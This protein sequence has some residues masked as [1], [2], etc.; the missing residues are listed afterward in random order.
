MIQRGSF[1]T[2]S[3]MWQ[4]LF[5]KFRFSAKTDIKRL[6]V[7]F[8]NSK[9]KFKFLKLAPHSKSILKQDLFVFNELFDTQTSNSYKK[10]FVEIGCGDGK[11]TSNTY[12]L[13]NKLG[14][15]GIVIE[16]GINWQ[17]DIRK[18]RNCKLETV[19]I[20][21]K[22]SKKIFYKEIV[23]GTKSDL[24]YLYSYDFNLINVDPSKAV[25]VLTLND[26]LE[27]NSTPK[28]IDYLSITME[29]W[30]PEV[31]KG[32]DFGEYSFGIITISHNHIH[33]KRVEAQN[34]ILK[35]GYRRVFPE[36]SFTDDWFVSIEK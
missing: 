8:A 16:P 13:E 17:E 32:L 24:A 3:Y 1:E 28:Y 35:N 9:Y 34:I 31:L 33:A 26:V 6:L 22:S 29:D 21:A 7:L 20:G 19:F 23:L 30:G 4:F 11:F 15:N 27:K 5:R 12:L 18:N 10:N 36:L 2:Q 14:W 25:E